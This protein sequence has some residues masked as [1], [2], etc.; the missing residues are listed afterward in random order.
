[1]FKNFM[2]F[3]RT[4]WNIIAFKVGKTCFFN[5]GLQFQITLTTICGI[6]CT[7]HFEFKFF[8]VE[9]LN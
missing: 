6:F 3:D 5:V 8:S 9:E 2:K 4:D 1:M 7:T